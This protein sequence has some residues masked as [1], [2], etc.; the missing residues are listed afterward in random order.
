MRPV[1]TRL[2]AGT[3]AARQ[4]RAPCKAPGAEALGPGSRQLGRHGSEQGVDARG[5]G[6]AQGAEGAQGGPGGE[7]GAE[8]GAGAGAP[9]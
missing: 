3:L 2:D 6:H 1:R 7:V 5:A 8:G 9:V 4:P